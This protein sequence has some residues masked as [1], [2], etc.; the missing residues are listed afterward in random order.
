MNRF[1]PFLLI[2]VALSPEIS[3]AAET[4]PAD[5]DIYAKDNL[6]AWCIVPFDGNKRGPAE[7]AAMCAKLG[8]TQI[9][10]DWR[11]EH[12]P[13]FEQEI[14]EYKKH[15]LNYFAFWGV[16]D[17]AFRL[18]AK[19]DLHPQIWTMLAM[20]Q[21][22]TEAERVKSAATQ[23]LPLVERT[24]A[25]GCQLGL[26]N[27]G[28]WGGEPENMV[29]VC[30]FLRQ[31]HNGRH[32]GIVYNQHHAHH[33][34]DDFAK[35]I[36][37]M[38][39]YLL[40]LNLN[41]MTRDGDQR[42]QKILPLGE[43]EFDVE[44][45]QTI[46]DSGYRGR[47][48]IIGH[49]QDDVELRLRDNLDGLAWIRP[50]LDGRP[51]GPKPSPRTWSPAK[52]APLPRGGKVPGVLLEG[53]DAYRTAPLTVECRATLPRR[54]DYNILVASDTK[55]SSTH[56]ELFTV[57]GS[58]LLTA[59]TP[60]LIPD[61]TRS[62]VM[63]CDGR[64]HNI[65]LVRETNRIRLY[66]DG[67]V[68]ADQAVKHRPNRRVP[69]GFAIGRLVEGH[70]GC[71]GPIDWVRIS[72]GVR[73]ANWSRASAPPRDDATLLHWQAKTGPP[74]E[75]AARDAKPD[76]RDESPT[77]SRLVPD[78]S[79]ELVD[80]LV[81]S[82]NRHGNAAR[83][84]M[85]FAD[86]KSACL[87]CHQLGPHGGSVGPPLTEIGQ[88][89]KPREIIESV[90]WPKRQVRTEHMAHLV[91]TSG[92]I[93]T[94]G[95]VVRESETEI[96]LRDPTKGPQHALT[97]PQAEI[98]LRREIGSLMPEQLLAAMSEQQVADLLKFLFGLGRDEGVP[99]A[100]MSGVLRHALAHQHGPAE[101]PFDRTP[102]HP[103]NWPHW[104]ANINRDRLYDFYAKEADYFRGLAKAKQPVPTV[105][106]E[107]P[108]LDGGTLGHWGNQNEE[109]WASGAWN[110]VQLGS[111]QGGIFRGGGVTV[112]RGVCLQL[113]EQ[114]EL[115]CC[116]NP[117]T[118]SYD[119]VWK[120]GFVNFSSVRH[121]FMHG[122][123]MDGTM[124]PF[125]EQGRRYLS[126]Q[127][128]DD[129]HY[130][131]Y[132]RVGRRVAFVYRLGKT[133]YLDAPWVADGKFVRQVAPFEDHPLATRLAHAPRQWPATLDTAIRH[134]GG[135]PYAV[136]TIEM[137]A[138]NPWNVPL[139]GGGLGFQQDG[140]ALLC[141]MH[142][143][144]WRITGVGYPSTKATWTRFASGLHHCQGMVVDDEGIFVL[145]RDQI[146]RLQDLNNDGEADYYQ[147]FSNA[148]QTSAAGHDFICGLERDPAGYF[149]TASGNQGIVRISPDGS[150]ATVV[151]TGF[152]NPD[153]IGLTNDGVITVPCSEGSWTPASM[154]CAF[155]KPR[156]TPIAGAPFFGYPGPQDGQPPA[157]PL[158][159]LP[160][161]LDNSAGGQQVVQ[162]DR[163]GPLRDQLLHFS[164]GT[165]THFLVLRDEV[166]GQ[167]Q[168]AVVP[169]PG[170]FLSGVHRG[171]FRPED[172]QLYV[173]GMQGWGC[174]TPQPGCFQRVRYTG[175]SVQ[176]PVAF[177]TYRN[178][179]LLTFAERLQPDVAGEA[180]NHFAQCWN[181][182]YSSAYGSPEF[183][184][185]HMGMRGHDHVA[186]T[187]AHVVRDGRSLFLEIPDIQPVNQ[188]HLRVQ[189]S[190][191]TVHELFVT[192]HAL[193]EEDFLEAP[194]LQPRPGKRIQAH[195]IVADLAMAT[196]SIPNPFAKKKNG[197]RQ[198]TIATGSNLS[199]QTRMIRARPGELIEFTLNNPDVVP[200]NWALVKPGTLKRVG[201]L[202]NRMISDPEAAIR[203]YIPDS[204][205]VLAFTDVVL[206]KEQFTIYF[207][208]PDQPGRY[209]FLCTF[210]GHWL[211]M[212]GELVVE[213]SD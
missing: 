95:Y 120:G 9:A 150:Q 84:M 175:A 135:S 99:L 69:G 115:A 123:S 203:H 105:L 200:H 91:V 106:M 92:G 170:E 68:V 197:G 21:G 118:L 129:F 209:P 64:P 114:G 33:R 148:Y 67:K 40:C 86:A 70:F 155:P 60:G 82:A 26:Y 117:D 166:A 130:E 38:K 41:G 61:H 8:L 16:H 156:E 90:L 124:V 111:V 194:G 10:Y 83:G 133:R 29:A 147:C 145:G 198:V 154:I 20:P 211:V 164:F 53:H 58:G 87:S 182:R 121:G 2:C 44:L 126:D 160:R 76:A 202:A 199:F 176:I 1:L 158:V 72:S 151:A 212:N 48:G 190:A 51:A 89:R 97:I 146:T 80:G 163:W 100:D 144:V 122:L 35:I 73:E 6:V 188:L 208:A 39:P 169:L 79:L 94:S 59:Y 36:G 108:G 138:E 77:G 46:R 153:G 93:S 23:L 183:S 187:T 191:Q 186:I 157:L 195:P 141:T 116:F 55:D 177:K 25:M 142:G 98:E 30:E 207:T 49:T 75:P 22:A 159:Y 57:A 103:D 171:R 189:S 102:L 85:V 205:D 167:M 4:P 42:G 174:Y 206:P 152:R 11:A 140:S 17:D 24:R 173:T 56:W 43:G 15:G 52:T 125:A 63:L 165:G 34:I 71:S 179:V 50:Q 81:E 14:L 185:R 213:A 31:H 172:G 143:D 184:T 134:G 180:V 107:F 109:T 127:S 168:G 119:A 104:Q 112:P 137:P 37:M 32:V 62:E 149:Y 113:G 131:G 45:L 47:I 193:E 161:G 96:V 65:A 132:Y 54:D 196:R 19:Y 210:P 110:D 136:D 18:F 74:A 201:E 28:G 27:H 7:R 3:G 181:Y 101:F 5:V 204:T 139:F 88:Q 192:V 128:S 12:V 78:Y 66:V 13:T 178:G 162:S